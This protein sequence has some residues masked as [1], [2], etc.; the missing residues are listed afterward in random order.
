MASGARTRYAKS[1]GVDVGYHVLGEGPID[2]LLFAGCAIP[3]EWMD[4]VSSFARFNAAWRQS[5][6]SGRSPPVVL[7][8]IATAAIAPENDQV[9][10]PSRLTGPT[11]PTC[12]PVS[13]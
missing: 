1:S 7:R 13:Q 2:L 9:D 5:V 10:E 6:G 12:A 4:D 3:I 11:N 8:V